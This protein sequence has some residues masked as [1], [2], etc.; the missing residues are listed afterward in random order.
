MDQEEQDQTIQ[1]EKRKRSS[2]VTPEVKSKMLELEAA[3]KTRK[4]IAE[5]TGYHPAVVTRQLGAG[6]KPKHRLDVEPEPA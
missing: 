5:E 4:A 1:V 6:T 3:G 2:N